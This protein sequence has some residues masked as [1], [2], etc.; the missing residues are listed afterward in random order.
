MRRV[1]LDLFR[2][3][4]AL[5]LLAAERLSFFYLFI[6]FYFFDFNVRCLMLCLVE[7]V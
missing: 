3:C 7:S 5:R 1:V 2:V 4:V 6:L